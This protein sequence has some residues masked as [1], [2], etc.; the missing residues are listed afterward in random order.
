[1]PQWSSMRAWRKY[2]LIAV[3]SLVSTV[4]RWSMTFGSAFM[5]GLPCRCDDRPTLA[6]LRTRAL[7]GCQQLRRTFVCRD[8]VDDA[9]HSARAGPALHDAAARFVHLARPPGTSMG[10]VA[11]MAISQGV[12][13]ADIH[14]RLAQTCPA[15]FSVAGL[16]LQLIRSW[17][18]MSDWNAGPRLLAWRAKTGGNT[19]YH[20]DRGPAL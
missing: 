8:I 6:D 3:S 11:D 13:E 17:S 1:M 7:V 10:G 15:V 20:Q 14:G 9:P 16:P 2:W 4:F 5:C 19:A 12:A 18:S